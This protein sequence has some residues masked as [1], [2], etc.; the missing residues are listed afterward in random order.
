MRGLYIHLSGPWPSEGHLQGWGRARSGW[1]GLVAWEAPMRVR[2][3]PERWAL[4][5][6]VPSARISKPNYTGER[7]LSRMILPAN[8]IEWPAPTEIDVDWFVGRWVDGE[9]VLPAGIEV[10]RRPAWQRRRES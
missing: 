10:D 4:A 5:A 7:R 8:P 2:G 6:W 3:K 9:I 1:F